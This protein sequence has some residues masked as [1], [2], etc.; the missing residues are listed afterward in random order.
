M[1]KRNVLVLF[2]V[3]AVAVL[4]VGYVE[5]MADDCG[6]CSV[7]CIEGTVTVNRA[8]T[9]NVTIT[10]TKGSTS[11]ECATNEDGEYQICN[12]SAGNWTV[13]ATYGGDSDSDSVTINANDTRCK[14]VDFDL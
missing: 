11:K 2:V 1:S 8:P 10:A 13:T 12:L 7:L 9:E 4:L 3:M 14:T 5:I 6:G